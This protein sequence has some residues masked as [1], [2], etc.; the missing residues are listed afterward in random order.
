MANNASKL[1]VALDVD[2]FDEARSLI[3]QLSDVV[4]IFK[5]GS[6]LF[7]SCG[8]VAVRYCL[9]KGCDV[10]L[11]LK[12]HDI[13]NTVGNAVRAAVQ[14]S[15]EVHNALE[16]PKGQKS[17]IFMCTLH[18]QGGPEMMQKAAEAATK[19]AQPALPS[20]ACRHRRFRSGQEAG[21][22]RNR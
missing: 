20:S 19:T 3:D 2:T 8:P 5:I 4:K 22:T 18:T 7:T 9:A 12:W 1:I 10:F 11:D 14:L 21:W 15:E 17:G 6:Q 13:P 16:Q